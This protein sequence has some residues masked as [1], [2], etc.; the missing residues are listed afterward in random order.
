MEKYV[1]LQPKKKQKK[2]VDIIHNSTHTVRRAFQK[3]EK[4]PSQLHA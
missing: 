2:T 3:K 1:K 4:K